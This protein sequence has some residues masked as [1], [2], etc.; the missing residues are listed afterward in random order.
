VNSRQRKQFRKR[1]EK[2]LGETMQNVTGFELSEELIRVSSKL[3]RIEDVYCRFRVRLNES[4][5]PH[6]AGHWFHLV[7]ADEAA[8]KALELHLANDA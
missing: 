5:G 7:P 4:H 2:I 1:S 6:L 8:R 3:A